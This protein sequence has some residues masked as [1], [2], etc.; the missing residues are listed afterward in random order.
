MLNRTISECQVVSSEHACT[1]GQDYNS[2][3]NVHTVVRHTLNAD[4][5]QHRSESL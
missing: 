1:T 5:V 2:V 3:R 4:D